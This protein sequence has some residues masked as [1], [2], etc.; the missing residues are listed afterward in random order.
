M[1][2]STASRALILKQ[3][4]ARSV[5]FTQL[6]DQYTMDGNTTHGDT[7]WFFGELMMPKEFQDA[8]KAHK[9]G[10]IFV[11]DVSDKQWHYIVKRPTDDDDKKDMTVL[12][13]PTDDNLVIHSLNPPPRARSIVCYCPC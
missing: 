8:V 13:A 7:G 5:P 10:D 6:S 2:R 1:P 12:H 3:A 9:L 11:V 4:N